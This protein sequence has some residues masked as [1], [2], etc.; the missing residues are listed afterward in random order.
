MT[1]ETEIS[2]LFTRMNAAEQAI[3]NHNASC[4]EHRKREDD[5]HNV[6]LEKITELAMRQKTTEE[7]VD[8]FSQ[9]LT[10]QRVKLGTL[11]A[12]TTVIGTIV[13]NIAVAWLTK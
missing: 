11:L 7:K 6:Y 3:S 4:T 8:G 13:G 10:E 5:R 1:N 9:A 2:E 12:F